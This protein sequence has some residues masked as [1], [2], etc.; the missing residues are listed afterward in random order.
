[1]ICWFISCF[2]SLTLHTTN[3]IAV[4]L[5]SVI[6]PRKN[7]YSTILV[8]EHFVMGKYVKIYS[9]EIFSNRASNSTR[10][11]WRLYTRPSG[12]AKMSGTQC[13]SSRT[14][15]SLFGDKTPQLGRLK[16]GSERPKP[17]TITDQNRWWIQGWRDGMWP[18]KMARKNFVKSRVCFIVSV[19]RHHLCPW[20][21]CRNISDASVLWCPAVPVAHHFSERNLESQCD[22]AAKMFFVPHLG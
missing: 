19:L 9:K 13:L 3:G 4:L 7:N 11:P 17:V 1:M 15:V 12:V 21:I 2:S 18:N 20:K 8:I 5:W 16:I 14:L 6:V 10:N 22:M